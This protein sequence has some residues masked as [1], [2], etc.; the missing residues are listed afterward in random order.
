M[1]QTKKMRGEQQA[2]LSA[3]KQA[4]LAKWLRDGAQAKDEGLS[5]AIP[6]RAGT[7]AP[8]L[9]SEQQRFWFFHQLEPAS[10]LY[11]MP[12][13]ARLRGPFQP[14]ALEQALDIVVARHDVLRT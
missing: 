2:G 12:I 10:P 13:G 9:S 1:N 8:A 7:E 5:G 3:A 6:R 4:L 11:T 14:E